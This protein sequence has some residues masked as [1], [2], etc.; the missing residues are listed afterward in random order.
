MCAVMR[1]GGSRLIFWTDPSSKEKLVRLWHSCVEREMQFES[2]VPHS[3]EVKMESS[4]VLPVDHISVVA[5][6]KQLWKRGF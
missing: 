4:G 6:R 2:C 5:R 3:F 1:A